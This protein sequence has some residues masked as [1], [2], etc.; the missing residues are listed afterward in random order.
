MEG[1]VRVRDGV[2]LMAVRRIPGARPN[3]QR[4]E[5][6]RSGNKGHGAPPSDE[7]ASVTSGWTP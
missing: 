1:D 4:P 2:G 7:V 6:G 5:H 3:G